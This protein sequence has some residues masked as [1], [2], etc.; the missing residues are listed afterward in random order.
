MGRRGGRSF[1]R[2]GFIGRNFGPKTKAAT[3]GAAVGGGAGYAVGQRRGG[4]EE[5]TREEDISFREAITPNNI[6][7]W[8]FIAFFVWFFCKEYK[9]IPKIKKF[10][11]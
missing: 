2:K 1:G 4:G 10:I 9:I 3:A 8:L 6:M 7:G 11:K 5:T